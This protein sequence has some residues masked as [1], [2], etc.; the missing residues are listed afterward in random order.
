MESNSKNE[1]DCS[2]SSSTTIIAA[3]KISKNNK[4]IKPRLS[5]KEHNVKRND[6]GTSSN[7]SRE[8]F[9]LNE[10]LA[11]IKAP[12]V[13]LTPLDKTERK[14]SSKS[15]LYIGNLPPKVAEDSVTKL[16]AKYGEVTDVFVNDAKNFA[17]LK[18]DYYI[19]ALKAKTE[20]NGYNFNGKYLVVRFAQ[21]ASIFIEN[22]PSNVSDELLQLAFSAF[23]DVE[24]CTVVVDTY[25]KP[26]G[27]GIVHFAKRGSASLAKKR[28]AENSFFLT[29][30]LKPV[31]VEDYEPISDMDGYAERQVS[32][33]T[34]VRNSASFK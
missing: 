21:T 6:S 24:H 18:M 17:F 23:G 7:N 10:K 30:S 8:D 15:R 25:G 29:S 22:L 4:F 20:L 5:S 28:C 2:T 19:N 12:T 1:A 33:L 27:K 16:F 34:I 31:I 32:T 9:Y 11:C 26:T 14:F 3:S 13:D